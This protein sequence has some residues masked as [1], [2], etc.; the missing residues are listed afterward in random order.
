ML[1]VTDL[2]KKINGKQA[3]HN[4]SMHVPSGGI[5]GLIGQNG[6]GKSTFMQIC[7]GLLQAD[8][9]HINLFGLDIQDN[10]KL[11]Q[12]S[13]GYLPDVFGF[14]DKIKVFEYLEF[15]GSLY[16]MTYQMKKYIMELLD[17]FNLTD[18]ADS[19]VNTLSRGMK[20]QLGIARCLVHNPVLLILDEPL[21]GLDPVGKAEILE[22]FLKLK[23]MG[24]TILVSSN[25]LTELESVCTKLGIMKN[26]TMEIEGPID[27]VLRKMKES[28]PV[29]I[30]VID[31]AE[32]ASLIL[33]R[34]ENV[35]RV[36]MDENTFY[37]GFKGTE[38][39]EAQ[40]LQELVAGGVQVT[41]FSRIKGNLEN[42]F[43]EI[44]EETH[45]KKES[46]ENQSSLFK[47]FKI[48]R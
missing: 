2:Q 19:Y 42:V 32:K 36:S 26:G 20:Q 40:L 33:Q 6:S 16:G 44:M 12:E 27:Q 23:Q 48:K 31:E 47:R 5:Y 30:S 41:N 7:M 29:L 46:D 22:S 9:G 8:E 13:V 25:V 38:Q 1:E 34:N 35:T 24:K 14:Y 17:L 10:P 45:R 43:F 39:Q 28:S 15:Y 21:E 4:L 18:K 37:V 3:L 11:I